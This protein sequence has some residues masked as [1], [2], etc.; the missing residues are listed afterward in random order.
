MD[1]VRLLRGKEGI[2]VAPLNS[3]GELKVMRVNH[4]QPPF[5]NP[6]IRRALLG[7]VNQQDFVSAVAGDDPTLGHSGV[8]CFP[9]TSPMATDA[10]LEVLTGP[11]DMDRAREDIV[12]AGYKNERVVILA[13][14]AFP[15]DV[16]CSQ[17]GADMMKKVGL[18][19]DFQLMDL[20]AWFQHVLKKDPVDHGGWSCFFTWWEGNDVLDPGIHP[21]IRGSGANG[22]AGWPTS[23]RLEELRNA[24]L[25]APDLSTEKRIAAEIQAQALRDVTF[26]PLGLT[27]TQTA[28]RSDLT[29]VVTSF[30]PVFWNVR[31]QA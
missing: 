13:D 17:V 14:S 22:R 7:I 15:E 18:N 30:P 10:G 21:F 26:I 8:G 9:P 12:A 11:R 31:R 27:H 20:S 6:A 19:V 16:R 2:K 1:L 5:A 4:L 25:D 24:W 29:G 28:Y 3:L 23:P